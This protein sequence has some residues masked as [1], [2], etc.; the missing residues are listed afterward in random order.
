MRRKDR[1]ITKM[2]QIIRI[3]NEAQVC[4]LA[5]F[6][7][8]Y[9]YVVPV[10]FGFGMDEDG[11]VIYVHGAGSGTKIECMKQNGNVG[12][13]I[14][15]AHDLKLKTPACESTMHYESVCGWGS[16]QVVEDD[17]EREEGLAAIMGHYS[18]EKTFE[19]DQKAMEHTT[20]LKISVEEL[21]G[22]TNIK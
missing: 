2:S 22:K 20:V 8:D 3:M 19:F 21:H 5:F 15:G 17:E 18:D 9:P 16:I 14:V 6:G 4:N 7:E 11:L 12:F 13:S 10:N 1:E